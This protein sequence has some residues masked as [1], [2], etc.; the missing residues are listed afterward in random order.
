MHLLAKNHL[1][2]CPLSTVPAR[3]YGDHHHQEVMALDWA[4]AAQGC[5]LNYQSCNPLDPRGKS[6]VW[7]TEDNLAKNCGSGNEEDEQQLGT[8]Q[9]LASYRQGWRS[10]VAALYA[11]WRD[12]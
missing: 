11:S 8:I 9:R 4:C 5:Q 2:P 12:R 1:Q 10:F 7:S 3:A 6:E